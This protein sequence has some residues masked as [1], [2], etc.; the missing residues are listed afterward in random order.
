MVDVIEA[1]KPDAAILHENWPDNQFVTTTVEAGD[2]ET[3]KAAAEVVIEREYRMNRQTGVPLEG[4]AIH[5]QWEE[6][7][8]ELQ[9]Y[10][11]TPVPAPIPRRPQP[12]ARD[13]RARD[14]RH[15]TRCR[16]RFRHEEHDLF[17]GD[18]GGGVG[19]SS[20]AADPAGSTIAA[21]TC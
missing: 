2:I 12:S 7:R 3:A 21:S 11:S 17:R 9:V 19:A 6:R 8:G 5:V 13:S 4:R 1:L 15:R 16:R 10:C 14:P 18:R 20:Q